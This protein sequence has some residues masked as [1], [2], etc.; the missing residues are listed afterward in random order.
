[1][2]RFSTRQGV[3]ASFDHIEFGQV[4]A[5]DIGEYEDPSQLGETYY[6]FRIQ[7]RQDVIRWQSGVD[8]PQLPGRLSQLT[9]HSSDGATYRV[10]AVCVTRQALPSGGFE[11]VFEAQL[12][13]AVTAPAQ[14][15]HG[16]DSLAAA[17]LLDALRETD[18]REP[19]KR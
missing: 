7:R 5:L 3:E 10:E 2:H 14:E 1:V 12:P 11:Y 8:A 19:A 9:L 13:P 16:V 15:R 17:L 6:V 18:G 4:E